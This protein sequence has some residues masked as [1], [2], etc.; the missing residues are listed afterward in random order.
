MLRCCEGAGTS[1]PSS[2]GRRQS[3]GG[4]ALVSPRHVSY[5]QD[6]WVDYLPLA[7]FAFNN[8]VNL[9]TNQSPFYAN[10]GFHPSFKPRLA[11]PVSIPGAADLATRLSRLHDEL[12]A[13]LKHAQERQARNYNRRVSDAPVYKPGDL[14]WL[15]RR[16]IK[17]TRPSDKL[18]HRRLGPFPIHSQLSPLVYKLTLPSS[19]SRLHPVFH[20]SLLE[21]YQSFPDFHPPAEPVPFGLDNSD[22]SPLAIKA[23]L[24]S[25]KL[26]QRYEY[27]VSWQGLSEDENSWLPLSDFPTTSNEL[28][29]RFHRR[30]P[31]APRPPH[32]L[33]NHS[34]HAVFE[35]TDNIVSS[36]TLQD[37]S[38][39]SA[40]P[41]SPSAP[42][43]T[44]APAVPPAAPRPRSPPPIREDP[45]VSYTP[46]T[47]TTL[48]SGRVSR[49]PT[50]RAA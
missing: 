25:R 44:S 12:R 8:A 13:E 31:R 14:V 26:G 11:D 28:I 19:L 7:E 2:G 22:S 34:A 35:S 43:T 50:R 42:R 30:H 48:R 39:A 24:D 37:P 29:E 9:S 1:G 40:P 23:I 16:N 6:D 10:Y 27:L 36:S 21:P 4:E 32:A 49:P 41:A 18:D 5:Q 17:T 46:P 20:V 15:L 38:S 45:R 33:F 3:L 47:Q